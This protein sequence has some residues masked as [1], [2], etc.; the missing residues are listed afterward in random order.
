MMINAMILK[1]IF[2]CLIL[3]VIH[4]ILIPREAGVRLKRV[5]LNWSL[6]ELELTLLLWGVL[7]GSGQFQAVIKFEWIPLGPVVFAVDGVSIFFLILTALLTALS[8]LISWE[9]IKHLIKEFLLC[10]LILEILLMG[11][12]T[13]LDLIV[14]YMLFEGVLIPMYLIIGVWGSRA[15]KVQASYYF[16]LYTFLGSVFML[17]AIFVV[18]GQVGVTDYQALCQI[19]LGDFEYVVFLG[20]FISLAIKIPMM[21]FHIW[22]PLAHVEAPLAGSVILAGVLL[23]LGGYG[24]VRFAW[25]LLPNASEYFAPLVIT[26]SILA[27]IYGSLT[28]CRQVDLKRI[29]AYSSVAHMGLVTLGLFS[30]TGSGLVGAVYLMLAHGLVSSALFIVVTCLYERHGTR[31]VKYYRGMVVTMP[32]FGIITFLLILA[33]IS[34]PLSCNFIGEFLLLLA[35]FEYSYVVGGLAATGIVLSA[36]YS[37]Y[38]YNRICFGV[39]SNYLYNSRDLTRREF[40]VLLPLVLLIFLMGIYPCIVIDMLQTVLGAY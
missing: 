23:K 28:T 1:C 20:I 24:F 22:L 25:P 8:I 32:I 16:F 37:I 3:G 36:G 26:L 34:V 9:S 30:H 21:P 17:L 4:I 33:N 40:Y 19:R 14:F 18:Y 6:V 10:L 7:D 2:I 29:I 27:I 31:L 38:L 12:F 39:P 5:V 15:E 11:V 35:A 13:V